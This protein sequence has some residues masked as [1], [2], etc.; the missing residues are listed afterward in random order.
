MNFK[1]LFLDLSDGDVFYYIQLLWGVAPFVLLLAC[2]STWFIVS[3]TCFQVTE[4][5]IKM[6]SSCIALLYLLWPALCSQTFSIFACRS[7]CD[8]DRLFLRVDLNEVCWEGKHELY[9]F[10]LGIPM[11]ILFVV[12]LPVA[13]FYRVRQIH[14]NPSN[15]A[16]NVIQVK[17]DQRILACFTLLFAKKLGGGKVQ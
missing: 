2:V 14:R 10:G 4:L 17:E 13:A 9:A 7:V 1:C 11:L 16:K 8:E 12:G 3:K 15:T 6:K 5:K